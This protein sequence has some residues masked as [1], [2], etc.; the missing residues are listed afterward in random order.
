MKAE[1]SKQL[2]S[3]IDEQ[4]AN[5]L[6]FLNKGALAIALV[7]TDRARQMSFPLDREDF[8]TEGGG[9]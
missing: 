5:K 4:K 3:F 1:L 2:Q 7:V 9:R 6:E 8:I